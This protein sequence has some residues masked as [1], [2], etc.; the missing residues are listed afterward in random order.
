M[1]KRVI[2]ILIIPVL[3]LSLWL[4]ALQNGVL[5][6]SENKRTARGPVLFDEGDGFDYGAA[7][8]E[9]T[10]YLEEEASAATIEDVQVQT[11]E[12]AAQETGNSRGQLDFPEDEGYAV[13]PLCG[14]S[15]CIDADSGNS[16]YKKIQIWRTSRSQNQT[17][18]LRRNGEYYYFE[19]M[20]NSDVLEVKDG[21]AY[22]KSELTTAAYTGEDKQ[23][24]ILED[25]GGG[26]YS[27][28]SKLD[29][30]F[31][32]TVDSYSYDN[33]AKVFLKSQVN[34][35]D[36][37][38]RFVHVSTPESMSEWGASRA[39][40]YG[41]NWDVWDGSAETS[42]YYADQ[43]ARTYEISSAG[44][45]AGIAQILSN[46]VT[47]FYGKTFIL[48]R[49]IDLS[50]LEWTAIGTKS[51]PFEGNFNGGG[52][53]IKGLSKKGGSN[54]G[55]F[56]YVNGSCISNLAVKGYVSGDENTGGLVGF[57]QRGYI[58]NVYSEVTVSQSTDDNMAGICGR[59]EAGGGI[60]HCTQNAAVSSN[61]KEPTRGGIAGYSAGMIR[62]CKN[63]SAVYCDW[64]YLGGIV[65]ENVGGQVEYC[66]NYGEVS[67]AN[68]AERAGGICGRCRG[69]G[70]VFGCFNSGNVT[71]TGDDYIGGIC[72]KREGDGR[73]LCC[74]NTGKIKGNKRVGG[75]CGDGSCSNCFNAGLVEGDDDIGAI[76]GDGDRL[77][78]CRALANTCKDMNG[79][80][81]ENGAE[82][83]SPQD[84]LTGKLCYDLNGRTVSPD[85]NGYGI[86][87]R[88]VFYQNLGADPYP[89]FSG[90]E[91]VADDDF[92]MNEAYEV[93]T[94]YEKGQGTVT[95]A[96]VYTSGPVYIQAAPA[97]GYVFDHFEIS[98][99]T[100]KYA[101]LG[102][103]YIGYIGTDT[104]T[105]SEP[106]FTLTED[107]ISSYVVKAVFNPDP[108]MPA[109]VKQ[110]V[111]I[112]LE[113]TDDAD[114][115]NRSV[116]PV[117]LETASGQ[118][119]TWDV[120]RKDLDGKGKKVTHTFE[121]GASIP[122]SLRAW[123]DFGGGATM[124][125]FAMKARM[126]LN[127]A[128]TPF[129]TKS[130]E[131][132][133]SMFFSST[134]DGLSWY[135]SFAGMGESTVG[136]LKEDGTL[137][138]KGTYTKCS[139]AWKAAKQLGKGAAIRLESAWL[140]ESV[141]D[142]NSEE[143][144]LDLNGYPIYRVIRKQDHNGHVID[145][146]S[147]GTL[148][149][150]DSAPE[151][152]SGDS[153]A[154]GSLQGGNSDDS[155]GLINCR[156]T[157]YMKGGT[158][159]NGETTD[160]GSAVH[161]EGGTI[162]LD[163]VRIASCRADIRPNITIKSGGAVAVTG[164]GSGTLK[165][166][167]IYNCTSKF[168][169]GAVFLNDK[170]SSL[171][172]IDTDISG[173]VSTED[174]GGGI[175]LYGG[176]LKISGGVIKN[177]RSNKFA[178]GA[179]Y[180]DF[181]SLLCENV[182]FEANHSEKSGGAVYIDSTDPA[183]FVGCTFVSNVANKMGGAVYHR[184]D[185]GAVT[186][187]ALLYM[188]NCTVTGNSSGGNGGGV[189]IG[190]PSSVDLRGLTVIKNNDGAGAHD[191]LVLEPGAF[192]YD[193]GLTEGSEVHLCSTSD[194]SVRLTADNHLISEYQMNH[195]LY[196][197]KSG[198]DLTDQKHLTTQLQA[199]AIS[200]GTA[201]II[202]G[203]V[204]AVAALIVMVEI[205][206]KRRKGAKS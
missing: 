90:Q 160:Y 14:G 81:K 53:A 84:V 45:L 124:R 189:Y 141:L 27:I 33:G 116:I 155:G 7:G 57:M 165:N 80:Q 139:D 168:G 64:N 58:A 48:T 46:G 128:E 8:T 2:P 66:A 127:G 39:D 13:V 10:V 145:I 17:W 171:T 59:M 42:W 205:L 193:L 9:E 82:W 126:W 197:D 170:E 174:A 190:K 130:V 71:S 83:V 104:E 26:T 188:E 20:V 28:K 86:G 164:E 92:Y 5:A 99:A 61:Y 151:R 19:L 85:L 18:R 52:H 162:D 44:Q 129:E 198:L 140:T 32:L 40:C 194:G 122:V 21:K 172:L 167:S 34:G 152:K 196:S 88:A 38:F 195:Y 123:P 203:I 37:Q 121:I 182:R 144:T 134:S 54:I 118:K 166:C 41:S 185:S 173:C 16:N 36:Q 31:V 97:E 47:R 199:S 163:G 4:P 161:C 70:L 6:A 187:F 102:G 181:G 204:I 135:V 146:G 206:Y 74:I 157:L 73:I 60:E 15:R 50:G 154:G 177:C 91:V 115:W 109:D 178:G 158:L 111:K 117:E 29:P 137:E 191:N 143:L 183:W 93:R 3:I 72:G 131:I 136:L 23:L 142:L 11:A 148:H 101:H 184:D 175:F 77:G 12:P 96:G 147:K 43:N 103:S 179:I 56:G 24:W 133:S 63:L 68:D 78:W 108:D 186:D 87:W 105:F 75:I 49:D 132:G 176:F 107:I 69:D 113:C 35:Y 138:E 51:T 149:I 112:E 180:Q 30:N 76:S 65:G 98:S 119:Y 94:E 62:Y 95:G 67:G 153:F 192:I 25:T 120:N 89:A 106:S 22:D 55:L 1:K 159:Y 169:G 200:E 114:G 110:T 150:I 156:G 201:A 100:I 125:S 202:A 79:D